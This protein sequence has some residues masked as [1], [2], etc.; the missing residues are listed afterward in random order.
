MNAEIEKKGNLQKLLQE[1]EKAQSHAIKKAASY[2][3]G[4]IKE[5][6][7]EGRGEW[8]PL[9]PA[10]IKR[11]GSSKPLIDTGKLR[12]SITH[13]IDKNTAKVGLF[14]EE[15]LIGAVHEF[16]APK[17]NIPERSF[18]RTTFN[19]EKKKLQ[20]IFNKELKAS[21]KKSALK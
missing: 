10:T 8:P 4:K 15:A 6:I 18:M 7:T 19:E 11:K 20:E 12:A 3:E 13:K 14:G 5:T 17:K 1:I 21:I 2:L 16:G 9:K